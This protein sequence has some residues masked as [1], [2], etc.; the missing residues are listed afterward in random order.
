MVDT[1]GAPLAECVGEIPISCTDDDG[2]P[3]IEVN[4][5]AF[6][7]MVC[8]DWLIEA[9]TNP[10]YPGGVCRDTPTNLSSVV[11]DTCVDDG[12]RG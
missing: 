9:G 8:E 10:Y 5:Y 2:L 4:P 1:T 7:N 11:P 6:E 3:G 12:G